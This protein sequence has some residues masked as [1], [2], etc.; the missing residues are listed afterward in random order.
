MLG[1]G[2]KYRKRGKLLGTVSRKERKGFVLYYEIRSRDATSNGFLKRTTGGLE[3]ATK[4]L[5]LFCCCFLLQMTSQS[6][7]VLEIVSNVTNSFHK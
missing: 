5:K 2:R 4:K 6:L 1:R 3:E 7:G